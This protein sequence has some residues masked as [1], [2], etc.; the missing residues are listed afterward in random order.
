[1]KTVVSLSLS[2]TLQIEISRGIQSTRKIPER[3]LAMTQYCNDH[4]RPT[5]RRGSQT[6]GSVL[7]MSLSAGEFGSSLKARPRSPCQLEPLCGRWFEIIFRSEYL[8]RQSS[9]LRVR[10]GSSSFDQYMKRRLNT[11]SDHASSQY[12]S[13]HPSIPSSHFAI[14]VIMDSL[15]FVLEAPQL[16]QTHKKRPRLVT[17]CDNWS[18][19]LGPSCKHSGALRLTLLPLPVP[20]A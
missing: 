4:Q 20:T 10:W 1:M 17:S 3:A 8:R 11:H 15:R 14:T 18:V 9:V 5:K 2:V 7:I 19:H 13:A 12:T 16:S 6:E